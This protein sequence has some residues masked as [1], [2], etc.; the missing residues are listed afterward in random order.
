MENLSLDGPIAFIDLETTGL[1]IST[2]RII[3]LTVLKIHPDGSEELKSVRVSP[4]MPI[5]AEATAVH[6][7]TNEDVADKPTFRQYAVSLKDFLADCDYAGF[8][9]KRFD[10][11]LLEAEFKRSGV[12]FSTQDHRV[13]DAQVIYHSREP[14]DLAAAYRKYCAKELQEA[15][16]S[17]GDVRA[18]YEILDAQLHHYPDLPRDVA[19]L[20]EFCNPREP[21]W[22]DA[23][24]R[25]VWVEEEAA[26]GF[27]QYK[28]KL[29]KEIANLDSDY[30]NWISG[31]DFPD[32]VK[33]IASE[34]LSNRFPRKLSV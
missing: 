2:D 27:G 15:H 31:T 13:L 12:E 20:H 22:I 24:G 26:F 16:T 29:L 34:A 25:F 6:G 28:G 23:E 4:G 5:P 14:R 1:S 18:A 9:I 17:M 7:I 21:N 10:L 3:E 8:N 33:K 32:E 11:P 30:L 19:G